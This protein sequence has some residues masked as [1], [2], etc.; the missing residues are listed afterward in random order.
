M[1]SQKDTWHGGCQ[2]ENPW[3][4]PFHMHWVAPYWM[5]WN[6]KSS[7]GFHLKMHV[8]VENSKILIGLFVEMLRVENC[9]MLVKHCGC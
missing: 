6:P 7:L 3:S 2:F 9:P 8:N 1:G 5:N 4:T